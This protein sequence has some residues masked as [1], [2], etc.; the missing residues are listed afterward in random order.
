MAKGTPPAPHLPRVAGLG[1]GL[2]ILLF[3]LMFMQW[4]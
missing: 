1:Q 2:L 3:S 4:T